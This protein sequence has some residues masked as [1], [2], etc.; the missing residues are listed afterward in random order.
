MNKKG[1]TLI[2]LLGVMIILAIVLTLASISYVRYIDKSRNKAFNLA[3]NTF[4]DGLLSA[5]S[6]CNSGFSAS[7]FCTNHNMPEVNTQD[8]VCLSELVN[9]SYLDNIKNP[10]SGDSY[11]SSK[12]YIVVTRDSNINLSLTYQT[13]LMCGNKSSSGCTLSTNPCE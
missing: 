13:C 11:C 1:F 6:E 10:F 12:S 3:V 2:E 5:Y 9:Y 4:E 8:T 7:S